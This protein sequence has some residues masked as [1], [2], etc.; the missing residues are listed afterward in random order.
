MGESESVLNGEQRRCSQPLPILV[1][2]LWSFL[3]SWVTA[4]FSKLVRILPVSVESLNRWLSLNRKKGI[5]TSYSHHRE[6]SIRIAT[7]R[8][9]YIG[10]GPPGEVQ[11][12]DFNDR[13][14]QD[15]LYGNH[16]GTP[17]FNSP[18]EWTSLMCKIH[19]VVWLSTRDLILMHAYLS[20]TYDVLLHLTYLLTYILYNVMDS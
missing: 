2:L 1:R 8:L 10:T 11:I 14:C 18:P 20:I 13:I 9:I 19:L 15:C 3:V 5:N 7:H 16:S 6:A 12:L 4:S 17:T